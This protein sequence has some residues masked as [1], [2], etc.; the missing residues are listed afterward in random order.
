MRL[1]KR[2]GMVLQHLRGVS[3]KYTAGVW[4]NTKAAY[5]FFASERV[6]ECDIL[7]GHFAPRASAWLS[8]AARF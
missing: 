3:G 6:S 2:F 4:A 8:S 5:G 7:A 1:G